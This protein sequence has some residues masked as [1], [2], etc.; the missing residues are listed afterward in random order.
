MKLDSLQD[1]KK[2]IALCRAQGVDSIKIGEIELCFGP[3]PEKASKPTR[4]MPYTA[5][6]APGGITDET[7]I[8]QDDVPDLLF[9]SSDPTE[10]EQGN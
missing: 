6:I 5:S 2:L 4:T 10:R 7:S 8:I 1:L 9:W 3:T